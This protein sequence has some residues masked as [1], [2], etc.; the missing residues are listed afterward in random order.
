LGIDTAVY[1]VE[2][3]SSF[4]NT[5]RFLEV[6]FKEAPHLA[7]SEKFFTSTGYFQPTGR[8]KQNELPTLFSSEFWPPCPY[9]LTGPVIRPDGVV[10]ACCGTIPLRKPLILGC[11]KEKSLLTILQKAQENSLIIG[12]YQL[13][14]SFL[15]QMTGAEETLSTSICHRCDLLLAHIE[16]YLEEELRLF[17][18]KLKEALEKQATSEELFPPEPNSVSGLDELVLRHVRNL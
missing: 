14:P 12:L 13:G 4:W 7:N 15:S 3:P 10:I 16:Q 8:G 1:I 17:N 11:L 9:V 5:G 18:K 2:G 6:L